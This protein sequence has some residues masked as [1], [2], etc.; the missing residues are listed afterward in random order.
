ME[1][2][3]WGPPVGIIT[4]EDDFIDLLLKDSEALTEDARKNLAGV[5]E[6]EKYYNPS[7]YDTYCTHLNKP[8][9]EYL[10]RVLSTSPEMRTKDFSKLRWQLDKLW[11][12]KQRKGEYNPPHDHYG[13]ISFVIYLSVPQEIYELDKDYPQ[14]K[15]PGEF[16]FVTGYNNLVLQNRFNVDPFIAMVQK[17]F[18]NKMINSLRPSTKDML[19]FPSYL[20]HNVQAFSADVER[21]SVSGNISL[22]NSDMAL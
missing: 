2:L 10:N 20:N 18:D 12:N 7:K 13:D 8:V 1:T 16:G 6:D 3:I 22:F 14:Y 17:Q 5:I 11:V 4:V 19:L 21:I 15:F 9:S